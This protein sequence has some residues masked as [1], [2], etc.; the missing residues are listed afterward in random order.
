MRPASSRTLVFPTCVGVFLY[1]GCNWGV[2]AGVFP[3]CV[4]VFRTLRKRAEGVMRLP[5]VR[6]GVSS[7]YRRKRGGRGS[8]PRAWGCFLDKQR[9]RAQALVFP[10]C[11]GVFLVKVRPDCSGPCLPHVRGGVSEGPG[12]NRGFFWSSP[13]AWGCFPVSYSGDARMRVFP[14]CVGV[15]LSTG[16][17][18]TLSFCLPH[19]RGGVSVLTSSTG[20]LL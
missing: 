3:T 2:V 6:G 4:G 19:V 14:T 7:P 18:S 20:E 12:K 16:S 15:F 13:R 17:F 1:P 5:H 11:V 9:G 10:T 8:S